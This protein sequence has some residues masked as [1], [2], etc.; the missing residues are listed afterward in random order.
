VSLTADVAVRVG[1]VTV[2]HA[3]ELFTVQRAAYLSEAALYS[4]HIP[5]LRETLDDL[6]AELSGGKVLAFAAWLGE[7]LVGSVRGKPDGERMEVARFSVAPDMQGRGIG[8]M[9]LTA[10]ESAAPAQ[11]RTLWLRTGGN[12]EA[13]LRLYQR[14]GYVLAGHQFDDIGVRVAYLEKPVG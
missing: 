1:P 8:R 14:S 13:N 11:V 5:P 7:R 10:V 4:V 6:R 9:L 2:D 3:G 12:S